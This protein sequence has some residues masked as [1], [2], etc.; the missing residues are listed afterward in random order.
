MPDRM[1]RPINVSAISVRFGHYII[2]NF[3]KSLNAQRGMRNEVNQ[4][5]YIS[6][7]RTP[8]ERPMR[9]RT[10]TKG[11]DSEG[12]RLVCMIFDTDIWLLDSWLCSFIYVGILLSLR[13]IIFLRW[14][15]I[16]FS[17][18]SAY[19]LRAWLATDVS[20]LG[21]P[22]S[23]TDGG[24]YLWIRSYIFFHNGFVNF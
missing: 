9:S 12:W 8:E 13:I 6:P 2:S 18:W 5:V 17:L 24:I 7:A 1:I 20:G 16:V 23:F 14:Y 19:F 11:W 21:I 22:S 10:H 15:S 3:E 4:I